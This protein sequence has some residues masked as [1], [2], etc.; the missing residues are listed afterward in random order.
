MAIL[1]KYQPEQT[2][3]WVKDITLIYE[4][5]DVLNHTSTIVTKAEGLTSYNIAFENRKYDIIMKED[6]IV[7]HSSQDPHDEKVIQK[8]GVLLRWLSRG[9]HNTLEESIHPYDFVTD[10]RNRI[11]ARCAKRSR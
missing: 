6:C 8:K 9:L 5:L 11:K 2:L 7:I 3:N 10:I 1:N 4:I